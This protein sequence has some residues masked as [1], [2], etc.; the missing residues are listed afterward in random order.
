[1]LKKPYWK[2]IILL[3]VII[4]LIAPATVL[5]INNYVQKVGSQYLYGAA[6]VPQ[7]EAV[8]VLGAYVYPDGTVSPMLNDRLTI[9]YELYK[10]GKAPKII[11]SG[12]HG[13]KDYDEVNAMKDF[14]KAK[15]VPGED[16]FMDHA[17][18]ST[19]ESIYRARDIFRVKK[20]IIVTQEYHL[21]RALF[22]AREL[23][24]EAYGVPSDRRQYLFMEHYE[25]R[26]IA[27]RNKD[28]FLAKILKPKP[29]FLGETIPVSGDGRLTDDKN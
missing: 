18:F 17:G 3:L 23:G 25:L 20:V 6:E 16:I 5:L 24:L 2:G 9:G 29:T 12:D 28:F 13:R 22:I 11:V 1:M 14:L 21:L 10:H 19:Y 4:S 8:L 26:E 15:N 27:A 7:A